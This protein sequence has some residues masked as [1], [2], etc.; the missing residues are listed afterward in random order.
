MTACLIMIPAS[1]NEASLRRINVLQGTLRPRCVFWD[2]MGKEWKEDGCSLD[3]RR[4]SSTKSVCYCNHLTN[5]A[6][7]FGANDADHVILSAISILCGVASC[8]CLLVTLFFLHWL[9]YV[10]FF[11]CLY[12]VK[13]K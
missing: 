1:A 2:F 8:A 7:I 6:I 10:H 11:L 13:C 5:F 4:S 12:Y 9:R 3:Y